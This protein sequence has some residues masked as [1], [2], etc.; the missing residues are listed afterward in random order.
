MHKLSIRIELLYTFCKQLNY[1]YMAIFL[2]HYRNMEYVP[3]FLNIQYL[4]DKPNNNCPP[5]LRIYAPRVINR[6]NTVHVL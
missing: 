3:N 6:M 2:F 5:F 4:T 1:I